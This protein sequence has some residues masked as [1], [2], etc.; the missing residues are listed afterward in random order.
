[1]FWVSRDLST[2]EEF[3]DELRTNFR[4]LA[5][6]FLRRAQKVVNVFFNSLENSSF[7]FLFK[8][9]MYSNISHIVFN[10]CLLKQ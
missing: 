10:N 5:A 3:V 2:D 9:T 6:V 7:N 8:V 1:M 4:F